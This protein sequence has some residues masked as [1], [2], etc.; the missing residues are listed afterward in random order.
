MFHCLARIGVRMQKNT[1]NVRYF[2]SQEIDTVAGVVC[3]RGEEAHH[4]VSVNRMQI[5]DEC[6][7][8]NGAGMWCYVRIT[9]CSKT[10]VT[11][12]IV[13]VK[14]TEAGSGLRITLCCGISRKGTFGFIV[15]KAVELGVSEIIPLVTER[16]MVKVKDDGA[17]VEKYT[18]I[19]QGALKQCHR[20]FE[21]IIS[22]PRTVDEIGSLVDSYDHALLMEPFGGHSPK[23]I[24]AILAK[25]TEQSVPSVLVV[26]GPEGGFSD[27]EK[28]VFA[29]QGFTNICFPDTVLRTETAVIAILALLKFGVA[30]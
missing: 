25:Q 27:E 11:G 2:Y 7:I 1:Q 22:V 17:F 6:C 23:E 16:C 29:R 13:D 24:V 14:M 3:V 15:E 4:M 12:D 18:K 21:P 8:I 9:A 28:G 5:G 19:A 20:L 30:Q 26:I 10:L